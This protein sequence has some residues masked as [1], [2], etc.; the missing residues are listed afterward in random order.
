VTAAGKSAGRGSEKT[1]VF[2]QVPEYVWR[3][4]KIS[5]PNKK[6]T[7]CRGRFKL[8]ETRVLVAS[9]APVPSK[10]PAHEV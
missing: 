1:V 7:G 8:G 5:Q 6:K 2:R 9:T 4:G 3:Y 10:K